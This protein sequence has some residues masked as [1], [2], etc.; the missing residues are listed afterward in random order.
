MLG[1]TYLGCVAVD[2]KGAFR[3][4]PPDERVAETGWAPW[5]EGLAVTLRRLADELPGRPMVVAGQGVGTADDELR[6]DVLRESVEVVTAAVADGIDVRGW[7]HRSAIDGY[8]GVAGFS[9][10]WGLFDRDRNAKPDS[11]L[12]LADAIRTAPIT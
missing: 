2:G 12:A 8:E 9:V 1:I 7:F 6:A 3:P 4:Y 11:A 10:P 5:P